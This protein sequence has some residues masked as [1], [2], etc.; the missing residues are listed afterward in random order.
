MIPTSFFFKSTIFK[1]QPYRT[2]THCHITLGIFI[3]TGTSEMKILSE[4]KIFKARR[5]WKVVE[6][7][8]KGRIT[9]KKL[10]RLADDLRMKYFGSDKVMEINSIGG[11]FNEHYEFSFRSSG[12]TNSSIYGH[13]INSGSGAKNWDGRFLL[14]ALLP[15]CVR[16]N[17]KDELESESGDVG[18]DPEVIA[19]DE[20]D[21]QYSSPMD[22]HFSANSYTG[23]SFSDSCNYVSATLCSNS[24]LSSEIDRKAEEFIA[25]FYQ[26]MRLQRK[27]TCGKC[28][29]ILP[30][31]LVS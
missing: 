10:Q 2:L 27:D 7:M 30:E 11:N 15:S 23:E 19:C 6:E 24:S 17:V 5:L 14:R 29:E 16:V 1:C 18:T 21:D 8:L 12:S 20:D 3:F 25:T 22:P 28:E 13:G 26:E 31:N 4:L 9:M